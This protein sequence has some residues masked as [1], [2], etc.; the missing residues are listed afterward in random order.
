MWF[1]RG[2][3]PVIATVFAVRLRSGCRL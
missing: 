1:R 3:S 2:I